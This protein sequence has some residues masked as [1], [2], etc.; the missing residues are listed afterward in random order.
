MVRLRANY[1]AEIINDDQRMSTSYPITFPV[2]SRLSLMAVTT[3]SVCP[4]IVLTRRSI[5]PISPDIP[6][7]SA[8]KG[9]VLIAWLRRNSA[10]SNQLFG[11]RKM[12][13]KIN[14][15]RT[16][17]CQDVRGYVQKT[18]F[19]AVFDKKPMPGN[20]RRSSV[21]QMRFHIIAQLGN[22]FESI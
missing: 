8:D 14:T 21:E 4:V 5:S 16:S 20:S 7:T 15:H 22:C 13:T 12:K 11:V 9:I 6:M 2:S 19:L 10:L 1:S 18:I 17:H 3:A